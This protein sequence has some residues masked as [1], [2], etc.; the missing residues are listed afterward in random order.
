VTV[1]AR[2]SDAQTVLFSSFADNGTYVVLSGQHNAAALFEIAKEVGKKGVKLDGWMT[3]CEC[4][5]IKARTDVSTREVIA[6][7]MQ[8]LS[9]NVKFTTI[10][11][12][13]KQFIKEVEREK[14]YASRPPSEI[15]YLS[16]R[17]VCYSMVH[18]NEVRYCCCVVPVPVHMRPPERCCP[19]S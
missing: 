11:D 2:A 1:N 9:Q 14:G 19:P 8:E 13:A 5:I 7:Q 4:I 15:W 17:K 6:G 18:R 10:S 12:L 16:Y 3:H